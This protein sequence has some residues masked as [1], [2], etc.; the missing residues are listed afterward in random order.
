MAIFL[1]FGNDTYT[2]RE[3]LKFWQKEFEKKYGGDMNISILEGKETSANQ[4]F[5]T[6]SSMPFLSEK[7]LTIVKDF[8]SEANEEEKAQMSDLLEKIPDFCVLVFSETETPD[9]RI[10]L[11]KKIQKV[12]KIMEFPQMIGSKILG[13]I[14]KKVTQYGG[15]IE[16]EAVI[17]LSELS[18]GDLYRLKNEI[19]KLVGYA[20]DKPITKDDISI[21]MDTQLATNIF[22]LTDSVGQK[23]RKTALETLHNLIDSGEDLHRILYMIMRQFRI[24]TCVKDL[25]NQGLRHDA[26]TTKLHEHPFVISNTMGQTKNFSFE[27][28]KKAY[29]LLVDMDAKLKSGG[30]KIFAGDNREFVLALDRLVLDLCK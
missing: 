21:L 20:G 24:I 28:I 25:A 23:N 27:Q 15:K 6:C 2:L 22:R 13:W 7:R 26:I 16:K 4:I 11:F 18:N 14:E 17:F 30:I 3:K 5:Q 19:A 8:L 12:G 29:E 9:R 10:S 1:F